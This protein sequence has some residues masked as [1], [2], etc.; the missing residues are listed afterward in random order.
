MSPDNVASSITLGNFTVGRSYRRKS[1]TCQTLPRRRFLPP[2][3]IKSGEQV[4]HIKRF[5]GRQRYRPTKST[6]VRL[7]L[8][9]QKK[10]GD[11]N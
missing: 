9:G 10:A 6:N 8:V 7:A 11:V 2:T 3:A 5:I 4:S 1:L